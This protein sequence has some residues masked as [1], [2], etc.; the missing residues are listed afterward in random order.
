MD[1]WYSALTHHY[2]STFTSTCTTSNAAAA[3][4]TPTT[5]QVTMAQTKNPEAAK[6]D[7]ACMEILWHWH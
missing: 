4:T 2:F 3:C 5:L 6:D 7:T 1:F